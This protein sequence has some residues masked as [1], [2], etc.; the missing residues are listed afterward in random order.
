MSYGIT[1]LN[2]AGIVQIDQDYSN[3]VLLQ[4]GTV[5]VGAGAEV[6]VTYSNTGTLPLVSIRTVSGG[7]VAVALD[8][9][10]CRLRAE[11]NVAATVEYKI[12]RSAA[13][14]SPSSEAYGFRVYTSGGAL[15]F[16]SGYAVPRFAQVSTFNASNLSSGA[17][18]L[19]HTLG[20][21]FVSPGTASHACGMVIDD[22]YGAPSYMIVPGIVTSNN[23]VAIKPVLIP[24]GIP[25]TWPR[26]V[27]YSSVRSI[28]VLK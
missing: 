11:L 22:Y 2:E 21:A 7:A 23:N 15:T 1:I 18:N 5:N 6:T 16:D 8:K 26:Y 20:N 28:G 4:S 3:H 25:P 13:G 14:L 27:Y 17:I 10:V 9:T 19:S 24:T 12:Y